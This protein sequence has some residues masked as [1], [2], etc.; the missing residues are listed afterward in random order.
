MRE[1]EVEKILARFTAAKNKYDK[2]ANSFDELKSCTV[3]CLRR[4][5]K[6]A[7][8]VELGQADGKDYFSF[9]HKENWSR[10]IT[11]SLFIRDPLQFEKR[12]ATLL[13]AIR[14]KKQE[15][16]LSA[17]EINAIA[18]TVCISF[19]ACIDVWKPTARKTPGTYF[20]IFIGSLFSAL[21]PEYLRTK[22]I[23]LPLAEAKADKLD[24]TADV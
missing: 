16:K 4:L 18:Y 7:R 24:L 2:Q 21:F 6:G 12:W 14:S 15:I 22:H 1:S 10:P 23:P 8:L 9:V 11:K 20:E 3:F 5:T 17:E 13:Q 19:A